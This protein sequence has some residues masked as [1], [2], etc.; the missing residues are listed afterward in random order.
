MTDATRKFFA[1]FLIAGISSLSQT[2]TSSAQD[3]GIL[4]TWR[5][6]IGSPSTYS[7]PSS[8]VVFTTAF[9]PNGAYRTVAVV[10]GGDGVW[11]A[12]GT[13]V[14]TGHY[15]LQTASVLMYRLENSV[16]CVA[17]NV[18]SP[19]V[20]PGERLGGVV[21]VNLQFEGSDGLYAGGQRW[22][23]LQ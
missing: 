14:M 11:G 12:G 13:Y 20:P 6:M 17:G 18:C 4:G 8:S 23:R 2:S 3:N 1:A 5:T 7:Q 15:E 21:S 19:A 16:L 22:S 9:E 10:E